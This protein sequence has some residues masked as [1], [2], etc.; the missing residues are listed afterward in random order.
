[1]NFHDSAMMQEF[2][3]ILRAID[4]H[5]RNLAMVYFKVSP[6]EKKFWTK[7]EMLDK[8]MMFSSQQ[9]GWPHGDLITR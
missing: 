2:D 8:L 7:H 1:M 6:T 3:E 5:D 4:K 9:E